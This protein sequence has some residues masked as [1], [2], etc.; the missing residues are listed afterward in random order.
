MWHQYTTRELQDQYSA[1]QYQSSTGVLQGSRCGLAR[2]GK[3]LEGLG[4]WSGGASGGGALEVDWKA[5][6]RSNLEGLGGGG[7]FILY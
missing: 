3:E 5:L 2:L 4:A 7:R 1:V 6:E